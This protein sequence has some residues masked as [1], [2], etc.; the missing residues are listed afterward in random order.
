MEKVEIYLKLEHFVPNVK[1][2]AMK[3]DVKLCGCYETGF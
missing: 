3:Q 1:C 2:S